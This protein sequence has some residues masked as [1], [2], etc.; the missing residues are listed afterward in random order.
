MYAD[1]DF[2]LNAYY[3]DAIAEEDFPRLSE[4]ASDYVR[5][6]TGGISDT[7]DGP[8]MEAVKKASCAVAEV[9]LDESIMTAA[10]YS[11]GHA[12]SSETVGGWSRSFRGPAFSTAEAEFNN[13]RKRDALLLYLGNLPAFAPL[14]KVRSYP[15]PHRAKG[16][17]RR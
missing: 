16:G 4:Q 3:G 13:G 6:A 11:G 14:F 8:Q 9:L 7:V 1:Y 17:G 10:L 2:Y 12:V 15:C 5:A